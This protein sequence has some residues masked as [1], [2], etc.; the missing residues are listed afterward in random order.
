MPYGCPL[1]HTSRSCSAVCKDC[2]VVPTCSAPHRRVNASWRAGCGDRVRADSRSTAA[3]TAACRVAKRPWRTRV[4]NCTRVCS[5]I[6]SVTVGGFA[7]R[8]IAVS[9]V[10]NPCSGGAL[11]TPSTHI[12]RRAP[13]LACQGRDRGEPGWDATWASYQ[14]LSMCPCDLDLE[15]SGPSWGHVAPVSVRSCTSMV[16]TKIRRR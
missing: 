4:S 10:S 11:Y 12:H 15:G 7:L 6:S 3:T 14:P 13:S 1:S 8:G 2:G 16:R 5:G 9:F